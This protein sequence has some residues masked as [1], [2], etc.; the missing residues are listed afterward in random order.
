MRNKYKKKDNKDKINISE[1]NTHIIKNYINNSSSS[2]IKRIQDKKIDDNTFE[3]TLPIYNKY[4]KINYIKEKNT[5]KI[6]KKELLNDNKS[7]KEKTNKNIINNKKI[8]DKYQKIIININ[9]GDKKMVQDNKSNDVNN[10]NSMVINQ[11]SNIYNKCHHI[12]LNIKNNQINKEN[13]KKIY[14]NKNEIKSN[15]NNIKFI[16]KKE[17]K[18]ENIEENDIILSGINLKQKKNFESS[19]TESFLKSNYNNKNIQKNLNKEIN[20]INLNSSPIGIQNKYLNNEFQ[21]KESFK[22][23]VHQASKNRDISNSFQKYYEQRQL[24]TLEESNDSNLKDESLNSEDN[25]ISKYKF[26]NLRLFSFSLKKNDSSS[27]I[28]TNIKESNNNSLTERKLGVSLDKNNFNTVKIINYKYNINEKEN[29][30]NN[31]DFIIDTNS[32]KKHMTQNIINNN[33]YNTTVN[34]YKIDNVYKSKYFRKAKNLSAKNLMDNDYI[35]YENAQNMN[36]IYNKININ[37]INNYEKEEY[38]NK[39]KNYENLSSASNSTNK[40]NIITINLEII[41]SLEK[42]VKILLEKINKYQICDKECLEYILYFF[43]NKFYDEGIKAFKSKHIKNNYL[44]NIKIEILCF[45]LC[46]DILFS[47]NFNQTAILLKALFN[48]IHTNFLIY[49]SYIINNIQINI[50]KYNEKIFE[51]L[52]EV[53]AQDS[54]IKLKSNDM[55]EYTI[56]QLINNNSKNIN[57]YY[58]MIIDNLYAQYY[59]NERN[60]FRFPQCLNNKNMIIVSNLSEEQLLN[61]K[62][63]FFYDAYRLLTNYN[64]DDLYDFFNFILRRKG[65]LA[66]RQ[67]LEKNYI[68]NRVNKIQEKFKI[69]VQTKLEKYLLPKK[70]S[71]YKYSLVLDLDETLICIKRDSNN[72]IKFNQTNNSITL[73]VRPGLLDFLHNMKKIYELILFSFGTSEYVS[74]IIKN[75][76]KNEKYFEHIL[77]REHVTYEDNGSFFKNLNLLGRDVKNIIIVDDNFNNFKYHKSNGICIKPFLGDTINDKNTLKIFGNILYKIRYDADLTGDI[78]ISLNKEKNSTLFSQIANN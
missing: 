75:I 76:E 5:E 29:K 20:N 61:I 1:K 32:G 67:I 45:F 11:K 59:S 78:R 50:N 19:P 44:D 41:I 48:L 36:K 69:K 24:K 12:S 51:R 9:K 30:N 72:R 4:E 55:N 6:Q 68:N 7:E 77:Y 56:L 71:I 40:Q 2:E 18:I 46:Y 38:S 74:P 39:N 58:K 52:E 57:N 47:K 70:R 16:Y 14:I 27:C 8:R 21:E 49:I 73:L 37:N 3:R 53:I 60:N 10:S 33:I 64:F 25:S 54:Q 22:Y 43:N 15:N 13:T 42:I 35:I 66:N 62:S 28:D 23:L 65:N 63:N 26:K 31:N 34:F 17:K